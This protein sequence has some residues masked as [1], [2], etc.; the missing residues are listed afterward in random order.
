MSTQIGQLVPVAAARA[1]PT[2]VRDRSRSSTG[3]L[4]LWALSCSSRSRAVMGAC[5]PRSVSCTAATTCLSSSV[6]PIMPSSR[7]FRGGISVDKD[8]P[9]GVCRH[10]DQVG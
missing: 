7:C 3:C 4:C 10:R 1:K 6:C 5:L 9:V 2:S 8:A